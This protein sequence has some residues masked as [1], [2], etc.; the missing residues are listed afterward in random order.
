MACPGAQQRRELVH[1][2]R[3]HA[4][5][6]VLGAPCEERERGAVEVEALQL[7]HRQRRGA[8]DR[9]RRRQACRRR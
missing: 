4:D 3:R 8:F 2:A 7:G 1:D 5:E 6:G 9:R